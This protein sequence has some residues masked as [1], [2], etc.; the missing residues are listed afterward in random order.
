MTVFSLRHSYFE[1]QA[2]DTSMKLTLAQKSAMMIAHSQP[3]LEGLIP[4]GFLPLFD[5]AKRLANTP[6]AGEC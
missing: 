2:T 3:M 1:I 5:A 4:S 6:P